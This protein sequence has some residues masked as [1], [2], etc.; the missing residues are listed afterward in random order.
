M[1]R[2]GR[3]THAPAAASRGPPTHRHR[4]PQHRVGPPAQVDRLTAPPSPGVDPFWWTP[5]QSWARPKRSR[6]GGFLVGGGAELAEGGM[7]TVGWCGSLPGPREPR[8]WLGCGGARGRLLRRPN[9]DILGGEGVGGFTA[10]ATAPTVAAFG[11]AAPAGGVRLRPMAEAGEAT[12]VGVDRSRW[13]SMGT[14]G[15]RSR[16]RCRLHRHAGEASA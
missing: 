8:P 3:A 15:R 10:T 7:A 16:G 12:H 13:R 1:S 14:C 2:R 4:P 6:R 11:R 5:D 9:T